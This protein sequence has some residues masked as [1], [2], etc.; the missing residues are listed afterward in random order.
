[1]QSAGT[2][3]NYLYI[4]TTGNHSRFQKQQICIQRK[5]NNR[6]STEFNIL[7]SCKTFDAETEPQSEFL[8]LRFDL[9]TDMLGNTG[10]GRMKMDKIT[11]EELDGF[12]YQLTQFQEYLDNFDEKSAKSNLAATQEYPRDGTFGG[13]LACGKDGYKMSRGEPVLDKNGEPSK[14]LS[15]HFANQENIGP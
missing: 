8:F 6:Q 9:E 13:P 7:P 11:K 12:E 15:V 2:S 10:K 14:H 3:I 5:R 4:K 1:M